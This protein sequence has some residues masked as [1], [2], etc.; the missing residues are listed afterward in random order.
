MFNPWWYYEMGRR[1][2]EHPD[3]PRRKPTAPEKAVLGFGLVIL[4]VVMTAVLSVMVYVI[5]LFFG[6]WDFWVYLVVS[7]AITFWLCSLAVH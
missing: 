7:G 5:A 6:G 1:D 4:W 2:A 3:G